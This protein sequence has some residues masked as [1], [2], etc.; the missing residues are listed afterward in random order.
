MLYK[1][2]VLAT[3]VDEDSVF[4]MV[5]ALSW[6]AGAGRLLGAQLRMWLGA[7]F[8]SHAGPGKG[9]WRFLPEWQLSFKATVSTK[10]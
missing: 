9:F 3:L 4:K 5:H 7:L 2:S 6:A 10:T 8:S 1:T